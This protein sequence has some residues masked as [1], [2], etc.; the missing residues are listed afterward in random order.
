MHALLRDAAKETLQTLCLPGQFVWRLPRSTNAIALT[1]D[2]GP[3]PV[4]TAEV[5]DV[6]AEAGALATFFLLGRAVEQRPA[7]ARKIVSAGHAI[8]AHSF[9]HQVIPKQS[10][11]DLESDLERCRRT[12]AS[13]TGVD[14][15]LFRPP[16]GEV[17][18]A[19]IRSV[20]A[21]GYR[22]VHWTKTF[23]DYRETDATALER[24]IESAR[25]RAGDIL[26]FHDH[27]PCTVRALKAVLPRWIDAGMTFA[28]VDD[29]RLAP[30]GRP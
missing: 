10:A 27:N 28:K 13:A 17:S 6:L 18:V 23:G 22:L 24:R 29:R 14:T 4:H 11:V 5:L 25:V 21:S 7:L 20:C 30:R 15:R 12:I 1:F 26:L 3:H 8:G 16:R 9:D 2:D 19:S